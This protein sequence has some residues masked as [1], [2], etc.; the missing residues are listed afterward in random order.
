MN[1]KCLTLPILLFVMGVYPIQAAIGIDGIGEEPLTEVL[2]KI[3]QKYEAVFSYNIKD[4]EKIV[5]KFEFRQEE[6]LTVVVNRALE[7][8]GLK[9]KSLGANFY[10]VHKDT[11]AGRRKLKKIERKIQQI[12]KL[13]TTSDLR[14]ANKVQ[15]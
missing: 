10:V 15:R 1:F 8:T 13:S 7:N 9:Y 6:E 14:I 4:V 5:V 12:G 3:G 2:D 11:K